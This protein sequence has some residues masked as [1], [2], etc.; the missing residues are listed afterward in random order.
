MKNS[1]L[2]KECRR[3]MG[4]V[5][6]SFKTYA[7]QCSV[8]GC[9]EPHIVAHHEDYS[10][11]RDV[12]WLCSKHHSARHKLDQNR[13]VVVIEK[14]AIKK[15]RVLHADFNKKNGYEISFNKF[16]VSVLDKAAEVKGSK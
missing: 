1:H 16:L 3:Q 5:G 8:K 14:R 11:P 6:F 9:K 15:L 2:Q 12:I 10:K 4:L 13:V 7:K